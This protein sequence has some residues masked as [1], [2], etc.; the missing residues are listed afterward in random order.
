M[1]KHYFTFTTQNG[2]YA[3]ILKESV[4]SI[5]YSNQVLK[6]KSIGSL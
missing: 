4:K 5:A 3:L 2:A 1:R 6:L